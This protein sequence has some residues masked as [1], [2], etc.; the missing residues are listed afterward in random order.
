VC[1]IA[2]AAFAA[3]PAPAATDKL[4][5]RSSATR[6]IEINELIGQV[7]IRTGRQFVVDPRV[8]GD[9]PLPDNVRRIAELIERLDRLSAAKAG[10]PASDGK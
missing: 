8:R 6:V 4:V 1:G 10:C 7:A 2:R 9:V 5:P 3:E